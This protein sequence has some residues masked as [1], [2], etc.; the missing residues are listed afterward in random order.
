[1]RTADHMRQFAKLTGSQGAG[2][3]GMAD[4]SNVNILF[5]EQSLL[6][7]LLA[8][9]RQESDREINFSGVQTCQQFLSR[10]GNRIDADVWCIA[11]EPCSKPWE[12]I[13]LAD[14]AECHTKASR[15]FRRR[16]IRL[17]DRPAYD[18]QSCRYR[19]Y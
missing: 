19:F 13:A 3:A 1:M 5:D 9:A 14:I 16:E 7:N 2:D 10:Y 12:E 18:F 6:V 17:F 15:V 4:A 11:R 8:K